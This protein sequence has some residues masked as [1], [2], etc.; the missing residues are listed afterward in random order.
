VARNKSFTIFCCISHDIHTATVATSTLTSASSQLVVL[1]EVQ[2]KPELF[3]MLRVLADRKPGK[4]R[5]LLTGSASPSLVRG[6]S[7]SL[8]GRV[9]LVDVAGFNLE[10]VGEAE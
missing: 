3:A 5:F 9:A 6:V 2:R 1:D 10:E 7:E 8:A 4:A